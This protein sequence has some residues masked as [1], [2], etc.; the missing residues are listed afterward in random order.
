MLDNCML[1]ALSA[2]RKLGENVAA[3]LGMKLSNVSVSRFPSGEIMCEPSETVRDKD[4]YIIQSTCPPVNENLMEILVFID[5]LKRSSAKE[6]NVIIPYFAYARQDRKAKPRQPI[7]ARLVADLLKVA[8]ADRVVTCDLHTPQIQGFFSCLI[9]ELTA[10]PLF[11]STLLNDKRIDIK[12]TV[13]VSPDNGGVNRARKVAEQLNAPLAIIDKRRNNANEPQVMNII[14]HVDAKDC[15][16]VDD[17]IDT[18]GSAVAACDALIGAG[19]KSV[20]IVATHAVLSDPAYERIANSRID[21]IIVS[22]SIPLQEKFKN[23]NYKIVSLAPMLAAAI[24]RIQ[25]GEPLSV[26]YDMYRNN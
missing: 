19:A 24:K 17:M 6:I 10:I 20:K 22:D 9:D 18:A 12:N 21:Q 4:I 26:V 1:F 15:I 14:G 23:K 7:T 8:G 3:A 11:C 2:N 5:S 25:L 13:I 16:I